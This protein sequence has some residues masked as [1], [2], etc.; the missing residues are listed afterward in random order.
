MINLNEGAAL[1]QTTINNIN[2]AYTAIQETNTVVD[3]NQ[4]TINGL[5]D[6]VDREFHHNSRI[7]PQY[8][9]ETWVMTAGLTNNI[10]S[11]WIGVV[12]SEPVYLADKCTTG[13]HLHI[14]AIALEDAS[15][16]DK[17]YNLELAYGESIKTIITRARFMSGN[18]KAGATSPVKIRAEHIPCGEPIFYRLQCETGGATLQCHIRF[19]LDPIAE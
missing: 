3:N 17:I 1:T 13:Y 4:V 11:D 14:T 6:E 15:D 8:S 12:D 7:F 16:K 5:T 18:T 2:N 10:F 19:H 9:G